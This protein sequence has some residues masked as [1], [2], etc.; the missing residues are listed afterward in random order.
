MAHFS[1]DETVKLFLPSTKNKPDAEKAWVM[2]R[3][4][5]LYGDSIAGSAGSTLDEAGKLILF[6]MVKD[7]NF[8]DENDVP[9]PIT[10]ETIEWLDKIDADFLGDWIIEQTENQK[11]GLSDEEKKTSLDTSTPSSMVENPPSAP[12]ATT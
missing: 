1:K 12:Q 3:A 10:L 6:R 11:E 9:I 4:K 2:M 8:T 7:W 5:M